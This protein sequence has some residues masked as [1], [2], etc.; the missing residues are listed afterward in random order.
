MKTTDLQKPEITN[1]PQILMQMLTGFWV[2]QAICSIARMGV[3]DQLKSG[4]QS[5]ATLANRL[6]AHEENLF[7]VMRA[8]ASL[9]IFQETADRTFALTPIASLLRSDAPDS[10]RPIAMML[11]EENYKAWGNL[12]HALQQGESPFEV[13]YGMNAYEYF[14]K[15]PEAAENF[16]S[17]MTALVKNDNAS[18]LEAFEFS[19]FN[20]I[21]DVGGGQGMLLAAILKR[22][23]AMHG[24]LFDLSDV[25]VNAGPVLQSQGVEDRCKIESGNFYEIVPP[26][27]DAYILSR[28][29]HGFSDELCGQIL[30]SIHTAMPP[31]GKLLVMEFILQ[32]GND[33]ATA[34]TKLMDV[35]MLVF[36]PGGRDRTYEEYNQLLSQSGFQLLHAINTESGISVLEAT[37][38]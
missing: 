14:G 38:R 28:V 6:N 12:Y 13:A 30:R 20:N 10:M 8:L 19:R 24:V 11:S 15:H 25:V 18:I 2:S 4:P 17:A 37:K 22:Y 5:I 35:N 34:R 3:A 23:P 16:N 36:A 29:L 26:G 7:R 21:V 31:Q 1:A 33:P 32:P 9:G 27:G